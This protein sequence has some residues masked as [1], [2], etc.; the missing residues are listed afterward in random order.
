M[1]LRQIP[2]EIIAPR[3]AL[4]PASLPDSQAIPVDSGAFE[5]ALRLSQPVR[6]EASPGE[7]ADSTEVDSVALPGGVRIEGETA[8]IQPVRT[9]PASRELVEGAEPDAT[10]ADDSSRMIET[11]EAVVDKPADGNVATTAS[12]PA[13][14]TADGIFVS[15]S[16]AGSLNG[17]VRSPSSVIAPTQQQTSFPAAE[18]VPE[19]AAPG[20][21]TLETPLAP[22]IPLRSSLERSHQSVFRRVDRTH[23]PPSV[24]QT[25]NSPPAESNTELQPLQSL[26]PSVRSTEQVPDDPPLRFP[27]QVDFAV[28]STLTESEPLKGQVSE[29]QSTASDLQ[30]SVPEISG[31]EV[32]PAPLTPLPSLLA[33]DSA[34]GAGARMQNGTPGRAVESLRD[35]SAASRVRASEPEL[36]LLFPDSSDVQITSTEPMLAGGVTG[37]PQAEVLE[38]LPSLL[39]TA[40]E[41]I[42]VSPRP[43]KLDPTVPAGQIFVRPV[44]PAPGSSGEVD[45]TPEIRPA[46]NVTPSD[47]FDAV[48]FNV[49]QDPAADPKTMTGEASTDAVETAA[50]SQGLMVN[51]Q[52]PSSARFESPESCMDGR[53]TDPGPA[54]SVPSVRSGTWPDAINTVAAASARQSNPV[55]K[56]DGEATSLDL[57]RACVDPAGSTELDET[58]SADSDRATATVPD[59]VIGPEVAAA[60]TSRTGR[61]EAGQTTPVAESGRLSRVT[62]DGQVEVELSETV[63]TIRRAISGDGHI[64]VR[65]N[66][67]ELGAMQIEVRQIDAGITVRL[68][69]ETEAAQKALLESLGDLRQSLRQQRAGVEQIDVVLIERS[70]EPL[71]GSLEDGRREA[72][73]ER[74]SEE[75]NRRQEQERRNRQQRQPPH[76]DEEASSEAA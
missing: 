56:L 67:P 40:G 74:P 73:R 23:R 53:R 5:N 75:Q 20:D 33:L 26:V 42:P 28:D 31:T 8:Q 47:G 49:V 35:R 38:P 72:D 64:K 37:V 68:E 17:G 18:S 1:N 54:T 51:S 34:S 55:L 7:L 71:R 50:L 69:V 13:P 41:V 58:L 60:G 10:G 11:V 76:P 14:E 59:V 57:V 16:D 46:V 43:V 52:I 3:T 15:N 27:A 61:V 45:S 36:T 19:S 48:G 2:R 22:A 32:N 70:Q 25:E 63:S 12:E 9:E 30:A 6:A 66:P 65:L 29:V 4:E 39:R 44:A 62:E 21:S 24:N